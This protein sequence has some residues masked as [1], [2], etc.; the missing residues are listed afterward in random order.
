MCLISGLGRHLE[1]GIYIQQQHQ[2]GSAPPARAVEGEV[3]L[4]NIGG[5]GDQSAGKSS[6][7]YEEPSDEE[8]FD[9]AMTRKLMQLSQD[10][11][12]AKA[13]AS[14]PD[15]ELIVLKIEA[16]HNSRIRSR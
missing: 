3:P 5:V 16:R 8:E 9:N 6:L 13:R 4:P 12:S 11:W 1:E 2:S 7:R 14:Q 10:D 15:G